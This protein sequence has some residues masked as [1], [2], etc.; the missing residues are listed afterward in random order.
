LRW[1]LRHQNAQ[2]IGRETLYAALR[3]ERDRAARAPPRGFPFPAK[4]SAAPPQTMEWPELAVVR[5]RPGSAHTPSQPL[6]HKGDPTDLSVQDWGV[7]YAELERYHD[8]WERLFGVGGKAGN[9]QGR[10]SLAAIPS[11]RHAKTNFRNRPRDPQSGVIFDG[12]AN[13]SDGSRFRCPRR[14]RPVP[15]PTPTACN[16]AGQYCGHCERF[17]CEANAK[18]SPQVLLYPW[19]RQHKNF[20]VR[21]LAHVTGIDYD[22]AARRATAVRYLDL[23][24]GEEVIQPADVVVLGAFVMTN[25]KLLLSSGIGAAYHPCGSHRCRWPQF[26][27]P[28]HVVGQCL[29]QGPVDQ[30]FFCRGRLTASSM[31]GTTTTS[32]TPA[33]ASTAAHTSSRRHQRPPD[34]GRGHCRQERRAG[35][36][37]GNVRMQTGTRTRSPSSRTAA[38]T[39]ILTTF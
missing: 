35:F 3:P 32:T 39:R 4:A 5:V 19:L 38:A 31:N 17:I 33:W 10:S 12:A 36:R 20:Q 6:W 23:S 2:N 26:L 25:T 16:W 15:T 37:H 27:S 14:I 29:L 21:T 18:A 11:R 13:N 8:L 28:D 7:T 24:S 22:K 1:A 34:R 9:L 30:S